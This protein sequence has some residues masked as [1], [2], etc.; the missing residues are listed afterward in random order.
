MIDRS[1][2]SER[3]VLTWGW[4]PAVT[5]LVNNGH[6]AGVIDHFHFTLGVLARCFVRSQLGPEALVKVLFPARIDGA[7]PRAIW[8]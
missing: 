5:D 2:V 1:P 4:R 6:S 7:P 8:A 3:H